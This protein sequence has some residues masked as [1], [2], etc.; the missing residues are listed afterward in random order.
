MHCVP[1]ATPSAEDLALTPFTGAILAA[2]GS[3]PSPTNR[4]LTARVL[5]P[6]LGVPRT[7]AA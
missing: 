2:T 7:L 6:A 5:A 3:R 4:R 1:R